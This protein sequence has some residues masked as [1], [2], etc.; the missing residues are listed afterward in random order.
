M[1]A[2]EI[3][4]REYIVCVD[5]EEGILSALRQQLSARFGGECRI[6]VAKNAHDALALIEDLKHD[7]EEV[8][9]VIA[10]QI[11]PGMKGVE[12]L[13][14][15][16]HRSPRTVKILLT[17]QAGLDAVVYAINRAGLDQ[18]I[19]KPWDEPDLRLTIQSLLARFRLERER[20]NLLAALQAKNAELA[21]LNS[22]L[23]EKVAA[24]T[25]ELGE[26]NSRL[27][28]L[29]ITDGLT[30]LYNHRHFRERLT[31]ELERSNRTSLPLSVLMIDVDSFKLYN[32]LH[33]HL[34]GDNALRGVAKI[35]QHGRR[36]NDVVARYGGEEFAIVLVDVPSAAA[37]EVA[38][39]IVANVAEFPFEFGESQPHGHLTIS[40]GVATAPGDGTDAAA[41]LASADRALFEAKSAGRNT[42]RVAGR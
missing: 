6:A 7:G 36:A 2:T 11:M 9:V 35:L 18:Y 8:A 20:E 28:E 26:L 37:K 33:G 14:E 32:D 16:N 15:V 27:I 34:A 24:R 31:L 1:T 10:D 23:E 38:E 29:A 41:V 21:A 13:E 25:R 3:R 4:P 17:G 39:R 40:A 42:V 12:L 30:G 22:T 5:D 19:P